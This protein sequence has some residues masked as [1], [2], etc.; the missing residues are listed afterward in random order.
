MIIG[1]HCAIHIVTVSSIFSKV[2][3]ENKFNT[4]PSHAPST[5]FRI[6]LTEKV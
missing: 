1:R 5:Q 3:P 6:G 4:R 2:G